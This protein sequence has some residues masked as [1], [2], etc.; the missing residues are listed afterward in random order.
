MRSGVGARRDVAAGELGMDRRDLA[1]G[2]VAARR[3]ARPPS[4]SAE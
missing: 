3:A 1:G 2:D 4:T